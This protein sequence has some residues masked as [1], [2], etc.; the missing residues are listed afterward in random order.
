MVAERDL[1]IREVVRWGGLIALSLIAHLFLFNYLTLNRTSFEKPV[2]QQLRISL[3]TLAAPQSSPRTPPAPPAT[4]SDSISADPEPTKTSATSPRNLPKFEEIETAQLEV[5]AVPE[6][7]K[8]T[9]KK[10]EPL[11]NSKDQIPQVTKQDKRDPIPVPKP[12]SLGKKT[13]LPQ[14]SP[15]ITQ[16]AETRIADK[17]EPE[18]ATD[19][20]VTETVSNSDQ[21]EN[22]PSSL[23]ANSLDK[24]KGNSASTVVHE[25]NYRRQVAPSYPRRAY[26]LGQQGTVMLNALVEPSG[27]PGE[28]KVEQ[29]SGYRLL[30]KAALAAVKKWEFEPLVQNGQKVSSWVRVPVRF[31]IN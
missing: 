28:L 31:V 11:T 10:T 25:A 7:V 15:V 1:D 18:T 23:K 24:N 30:D 16:K 20:P 12:R 21:Q 5:L 19:N 26:E 17:P 13:S 2:V 22:S 3:S 27:R 8:E 4:Q 14:P 6:A 9:V 29:S